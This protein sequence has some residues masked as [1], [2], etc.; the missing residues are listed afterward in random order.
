MKLAKRRFS[1]IWGGASLLRMLLSSMQGLLSSNWEWD[2][3]INL[4]ESDFPV[5]TLTQLE[6][7]L[8]ANRDKNFVKSHGREVQRFIQ[9]QGLDKTFVECDAHMWRQGDRS[10]VYELC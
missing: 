6:E 5:K 8:S 7:F 10:I 4:S 2:F 9:K 1:T 3:V